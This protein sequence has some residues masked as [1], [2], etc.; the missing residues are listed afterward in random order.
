MK[1]WDKIARG[2]TLELLAFSDIVKLNIMLFNSLD[3]EECYSSINKSSNK[4][5]ISMLVTNYNQ[6]CGLKLK[7]FEE[8]ILNPRLMKV[9][10]LR[11]HKFSITES[12][13]HLVNTYLVL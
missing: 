8:F 6:Y 4:T 2:T 5:S 1:M 3:S 13:M 10:K 11:K 9:T 7:D 12:K